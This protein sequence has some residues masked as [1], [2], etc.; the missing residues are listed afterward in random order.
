[1]FLR[2]LVFTLAPKISILS[3]IIARH[4]LPKG[5]VF[6]FRPISKVGPNPTRMSDFRPIGKTCTILKPIL[7]KSFEQIENFLHEKQALDPFQHGYSNSKSCIS[8]LMQALIYFYENKSKCCGLQKFDYSSAFSMLD[9][10]IMLRKLANYGVKDKALSFCESYLQPRTTYLEVEGFKSPEFKESLGIIQGCTSGPTC[11][12]IFTNDIR[13]YPPPPY[14]I[15]SVT[16]S[17]RLKL[18]DDTTDCH[19]AN[20]WDD[21]RDIQDRS[22][23]Q[24]GRISTDNLLALNQSKTHSIPIL[25]EKDK[26]ETCPLVCGTTE[27]LGVKIDSELTFHD[28]V[29]AIVGRLC[30]SFNIIMAIRQLLHRQELIQAAKSLI[31]GDIYYSSE[32]YAFA[33]KKEIERISKQIHCIGRAVLKKDRCDHVQN[34]SIYQKLNILPMKFVIAKQTLCFWLKINNS[35]DYE[36]SY[37]KSTLNN[38]WSNSRRSGFKPRN[39]LIKPLQL[40]L[41]SYKLYQNTCERLSIKPSKIFEFTKDHLKD[42]FKK[43]VEK[44]E[45]YSVE[46]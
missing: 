3:D 42:I 6:P 9:P 29:S 26:V 4:G 25:I 34:L 15:G 36:I 45:I 23:D 7:K 27:L 41:D 38:L 18:A 30:S 1:M 31:E 2:K 5:L 40:L 33:D 14:L 32:I 16:P 12:K 20:D 44:G 11:Y 19:A 17:I 10:D 28:Q 39:L 46:E 8:L 22:A 35:D 24:L 21:L 37:L 43:A 13:A